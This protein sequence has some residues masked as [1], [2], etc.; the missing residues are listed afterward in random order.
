MRWISAVEGA[1]RT[2]SCPENSKVEMERLAQE[3]LNLTQ[4]I[5]TV[6]EIT[7]RFNERALFC[8][9]FAATER[10]RMTRVGIGNPTKTEASGA[11]S[12]SA[13]VK[14]VLRAR[15]G[16][17][18]A[19]ESGPLCQGLPTGVPTTLRIT[20]G[21]QGKGETP[22]TKGRAF[23]VTA[24]EAQDAPDVVT[25]TFLVNSKPTFVLFDSGASN[26]FVSAVLGKSFGVALGTL[27]RPLEVEIADDK[28]VQATSVYQ[29]CEVVIQGIKFPIDLIPIPLSDSRVI[30]GMDGWVST[31]HGL[32]GERR[33][34][35][36]IFCSTARARRHF[37]HGGSGFVAYVLD[38]REKKPQQKADDVPVVRDFPDVYLEDL[39]GV[40]PER[41]VEFKI[42]LTP[43]TAPIAKAPCRLAPP[44]MLELSIQLRELL[45]KGFI[46]P[47][48]SPWGAP[49]LF[50]KKNDGSN[51][52]CIDYRE[53]NKLTV[54][55]RYPL[56]RI[57]DLFDQLQGAS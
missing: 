54:K 27:H 39:P 16:K 25:G 4:T 34:Q 55:N 29:R 46:R 22:K 19:K 15:S 21:R 32:T 31:S 13:G 56:S 33:N 47:S 51:R 37:Q 30:I 49:I 6:T 11:Y 9:E 44:E 35:G 40:P 1:F 28:T 10:M 5:E 17:A 2:C 36:A 3:Y 18:R 45:D 38:A 20:D 41:Q 52:M 12:D 26:S 42:D 48:C 43:S 7:K 57:D 14:E 8:P 24:E 50:V 23:A 53:L